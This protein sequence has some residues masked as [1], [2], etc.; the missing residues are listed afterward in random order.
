MLHEPLCLS[1]STCSA[2]PSA[3]TTTRGSPQKLKPKMRATPM[4]RPVE[5]SRPIASNE[6]DFKGRPTRA[7]ATFCATTSPLRMACCAVGGSR[8]PRIPDNV[9]HKAQPGDDGPGAV[10]AVHTKLRAGIETA[11][12]GTF[13]CS[14]LNLHRV[15]AGLRFAQNHSTQQLFLHLRIRRLPLRK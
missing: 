13:W 15:Q 9:G 3:T 4:R 7:V 11:L 10:P 5:S 12:C 6:T 1:R 8:F 14:V 2:K